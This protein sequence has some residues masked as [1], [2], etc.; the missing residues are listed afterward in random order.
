MEIL[1][2]MQFLLFLHYQRFFICFWNKFHMLKA[3]FIWPNMQ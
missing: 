1:H 2:D 3:A